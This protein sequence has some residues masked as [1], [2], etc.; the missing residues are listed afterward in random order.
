M[1]SLA[2]H[3]PLKNLFDFEY[4]PKAQSTGI[5]REISK[6]LAFLQTKRAEDIQM[7]YRLLKAVFEEI[8]KNYV[9]NS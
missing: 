9:P 6:I 2:L 7:S 4:S 3:A 8:E 5:E 1:I